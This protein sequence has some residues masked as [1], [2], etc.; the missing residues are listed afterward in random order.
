MSLL[1]AETKPTFETEGAAVVTKPTAVGQSAP[2]SVGGAVAVTAGASAGAVAVAGNMHAIDELK[3]ALRVDYNTLSQVIVTNGN[4]VERETKTILGDSI[5]FELLSWQDS[6]VVSPNDDKAPK[7]VV[8]FSDDGVNCGDGTPVSEYIAELK[9]MG[10]L[11]AA[12]RQRV[13]LVGAVIAAAKSEKFNGELMQI[14]LSPASRTQWL[15]YQANAAYAIRTGRQTA[16][17]VKIVKAIAE[18]AQNGDNTYTLAK[19][20]A[21]V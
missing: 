2:A 9:S 10:Y 19:F 8:R 3:N 15:R 17:Q 14:D 7:D 11:K 12:L 13:V 18:L 16:D 5:Q 1:K 20:S 6:W 21:A 4:F